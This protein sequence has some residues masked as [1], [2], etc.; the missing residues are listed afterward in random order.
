[1]AEKDKKQE[2][3]DKRSLGEFSKR[4]KKVNTDLTNSPP[5]KEK[6]KK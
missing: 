2:Y 1:M 4:G 3:E 6:K 5:K